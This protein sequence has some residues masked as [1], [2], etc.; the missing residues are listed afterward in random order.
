MLCRLS[1]RCIFRAVQ[2]SLQHRCAQVTPRPVRSLLLPWKWTGYQTTLMRLSSGRV[3]YENAVPHKKSFLRRL[4]ILLAGTGVI[5]TSAYHLLLEKHEQRKVKVA[6]GAVTR[7]FRSVV[8]GARISFDYTW[9]LW[10][11]DPESPEYKKAI[12]SCHLRGAEILKGGCL[13]NGG[14]YVKLGQGLVSLNHLLPPEYIRILSCLL[15][16]ALHRHSDEIEQLFL[17]DFKCSPYQMFKSFDETPI[18]AASL[19]QVHRAM[20]H[21]GEEVAVKVQYIDLQDRF[22]AD[23]L[24]CEILLKVIEFLHPNFGFGW[25]LKDMKATLAKELDFIN[26][27]QNGEKCAA[28]LSHLPYIHVP[29]IHWDK[30]S[31]RVLT[32]EFIDGCKITDKRAIQKMGLSLYDINRKLIE[33]F[34]DQIFRTGFVHGDPHPGNVF[35]RKAKSGRGELVLLDHGLYEN[36]KDNQRFALCELFKSIVMKDEEGMKEYSQMLGVSN[37]A[38][39]CEILVQRPVTRESVKLPARLTPEEMEKMKNHVVNHFDEI[40]QVLKEMP[41]TMI[42]VIRN[43]NTIRAITRQLGVQIDRYSIMVR[44]SISGICGAKEF[45]F[46]K[47]MKISFQLLRFELQI[48][49]E[50]FKQWLSYSYVRLQSLLGI[51]PELQQLTDLIESQKTRYEKI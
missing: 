4:T 6:A 39:F 23:L 45:S 22:F 26:E 51:N 13:K 46:L 24:T 9:S 21:S 3:K 18:A 8:V 50:N 48:S 31:K 16:Q 5:G 34:S 28:D 38:A 7:F 49:I 15:D 1:S 36:L 14:L 10:G 20:T 19:A 12:I 43:L 41:R 47:K 25:V 40:M 37:Y 32:A 33:S 11:L 42:L 29:D 44:R 2:S 35:V 17:E 30:T 27:G